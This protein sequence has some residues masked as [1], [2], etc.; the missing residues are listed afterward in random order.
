MK[1]I[2]TTY[3]TDSLRKPETGAYMWAVLGLITIGAVIAAGTLYITTQKVKTSTDYALC[4]RA[5]N[6]ADAGADRFVSA[7]INTPDT[8]GNGVFDD[9]PPDLN[10]TFGKPIYDVDQ[11]G[12]TD[13]YQMFAL[14][15]HV[16]D[17]PSLTTV[18]IGP[19]VASD[20]A[21]DFSL[22]VTIGATV[23]EIGS[24]PS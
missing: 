1:T 17:P 19:L 16:P 24:F 15:K 20:T 23:V 4:Q 10:D 21:S 9:A 22:I 18:V 12:T 7:L 8:D 3:K 11:D 2:R 13:F 5:L 6:N 14:N